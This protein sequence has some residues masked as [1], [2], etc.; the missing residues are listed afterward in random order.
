MQALTH[1]VDSA[2]LKALHTQLGDAPYQRATLQVDSPFLD[3]EHQLLTSGGRRAEICYILHRGDPQQG[4]LLHR[5]LF[6]P[7]VAF[8]LPT[9]GIHEG[10]AVLETLVRE[11]AE[12]TSFHLDLPGIAMVAPSAAPAVRLQ[13]FLGTLAYEMYHARQ[14]RTHYFATYHFLIAAPVDATPETIDPEEYLAGWQW[15]PWTEMVTVADML[16]NVGT[17]SP[18]WKDWGRFR[19]LSHRFVVAAMQQLFAP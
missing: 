6:Y 5:K 16:E 1:A 10:E 11:I 15:R 2:E 8:R 13:R 7:E 9:G 3:G 14:Q 18:V 19:A 4:V 17:D 12:E